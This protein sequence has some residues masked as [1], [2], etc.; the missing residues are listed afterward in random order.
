VTVK[1]LNRTRPRRKES[2]LPH[3]L[4][5]ILILGVI[6]GTALLIFVYPVPGIGPETTAY[7]P[8]KP[9]SVVVS[10]VNSSSASALPNL[11]L[12]SVYIPNPKLPLTIDRTVIDGVKLVLVEGGVLSTRRSPVRQGV[13]DFVKQAGAAAGVNGTFFANAS[14]NGTDNLLIGPSLCAN[15][16]TETL[17][18]FDTKR[19]L[20]GRPMVLVSPDA[21]CIVP[22]DITTLSL[23]GAVQSIM[24]GVTDAFL[25]GVWLVRDGEASTVEQLAT[26][27][28]HD[29]EDPRRRAFFAIMPDGRPVLGATDGS[30]PSSVLAEA[31]ADAG[32][33]EGVLLDSGFST[34]LVFQQTM[35]VTGHSTRNIPSR[36]VPHALILLGQPDPSALSQLQE[37]PPTT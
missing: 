17:S 33:K 36:P 31:L 18:P 28:V 5:V 10:P 8:P 14:L 19:Q 23:P 22:Y 32:V 37:T 25:G 27:N 11:P 7:I 30:W 26:F 1:Q 29:A 34:S 3:V 15:E 24:P 6:A 35:L 2:A 20:Q 12:G 13:E 21:T 9:I 16:A 4:L